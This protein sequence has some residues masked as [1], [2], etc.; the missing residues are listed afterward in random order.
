MTAEH[1]PGHAFISYVREDALRADRLQR[2]LEAAG[3]DVWRDTRDLWPGQDWKIEIRRAIANDSLV[4]IACFS[5]VS[6]KRETSYQYE[7]LNQAVE[8][9]RMRRPG[10]PWIIPVRFAECT[11]PHFD[12][13]AGK[14]LDSLQRIDL[15]GDHWDEGIARLVRVVVHALEWEGSR[16]AGGS[17]AVALTRR[18]LLSAAAGAALVYGTS[19]SA[20]GA[21]RAD[22]AQSGSNASHTVEAGNPRQWETGHVGLSGVAS[23]DFAK[24]GRLIATGGNETIESNTRLWN[25]VSHQR[26]QILAGGG[27]PVAFSP[28]GQYLAT[29][30]A[31]R[32]VRLWKMSQFTS[33]DPLPTENLSCLAFV[34]G[35]DLV[36]GG[37]GNGL[38]Q[39]WDAT[40]SKVVAT[41]TAPHI[42]DT[43]VFDDNR[44]LI[45]CG[46]RLDVSG[47]FGVV[48][49]DATSA[50]TLGDF[51]RLTGPTMLSPDRTV[52]IA[53][54][55][56]DAEATPY[57][58]DAWDLP[59]NKRIATL[60]ELTSSS[61]DPIITFRPDGKV[62][63]VAH[64]REVQLW[65]SRSNTARRIVDKAAKSIKVGGES[66]WITS[67]AFSKDG[68]T[69]A[70]GDN[71]GI[72]Y[73]WHIRPL[74]DV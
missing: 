48:V 11:L 12:L 19:T 23:I 60:L 39:T 35:T 28:D 24:D 14:N 1:P 69:L 66:G 33:G 58:L 74:S 30:T 52:L 49:W 47:E 51:P 20:G 59:G 42:V 16:A 32:T 26:V 10:R 38:L 15:F 8:H 29:G 17:S 71:H 34:P 64:N 41:T 5:E 43:V 63:A 4:F 68:T 50:T 9:M 7:E 37:C 22:G 46:M 67:I 53:G 3:V 56:S 2:A 62:F 65:N 25:A 31:D 27:P 18:R 72:V 44:H 54:G 6:E 73:L 57:T 61:S 36:V 13:G 21:H 40:S 70:V 45:T 55:S